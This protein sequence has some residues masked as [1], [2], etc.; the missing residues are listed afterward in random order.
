MRQVGVLFFIG[1]LLILRCYRYM[2]CESCGCSKMDVL[3]SCMQWL[4]PDCG[5][6]W[7]VEYI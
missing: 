3:M 6:I 1:L 7:S 2:M 4:C 5:S